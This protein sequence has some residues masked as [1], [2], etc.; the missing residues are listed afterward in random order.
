M[1]SVARVP[2]KRRDSLLDTT[3]L[4]YSSLASLMSG[5]KGSIASRSD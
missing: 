3:D 5:E 1:E 4:G 2:Q